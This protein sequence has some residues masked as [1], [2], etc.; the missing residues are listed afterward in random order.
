MQAAI[1]TQINAEF[2]SAYLYLSMAAYS[3][4]I[5]LPGFANWM[6][7]QEQEERF[8]ALKMYDYVI[9]RGGRVTLKA[10]AEPPVEWDSPLA[11]FEAVAAHEAKVTAMINALVD[12]AIEVKDHAANQF[13]QW[14]VNEQVEE[15]GNDAKI[16]GD[17]RRMGDSGSTLFMI[18]RELA[19]RVYVPP[20][21]TDTTTVG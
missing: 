16:V 20:A 13:L 6:R 14:F 19:T 3:Q 11:M 7:V 21:T 9:S 10:I 18:D 15:E 5:N 4:A 1:N 17:L 12:I 8:H 2:Y